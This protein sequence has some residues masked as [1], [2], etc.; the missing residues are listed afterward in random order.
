M[1]AVHSVGFYAYFRVSLPGAFPVV[2]THPDETA[3]T[4]LRLLSPW[5]ELSEFANEMTNDI[6]KLEDHEH[7]HLPLVVILLHY[8]EQWMQ[9]HEGSYPTAYPDKIAF[10]KI[11]SD[12]M[13][14]GNPEGGE[15]N[16]EEAVASVMKH[17][18]KPELPSNLKQVFDHKHEDVK[19]Q[20]G[21]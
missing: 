11:V 15:E 16:F 21:P 5:P 13:R 3:T 7:G 1:V 19:H 6:D 14:R 9:S 20:A 12:A 17:V 10:R 8:L 4:D 18:V 2:E